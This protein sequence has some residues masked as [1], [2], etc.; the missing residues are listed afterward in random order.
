MSARVAAIGAIFVGTSVAWFVLGTTIQT[1]TWS[2]SPAL[3]ER[4]V[5]NW[6]GPHA[7]HRPTATLERPATTKE[8]FASHVTITP[9]KTVA[10]AD[11]RLQ[12]RQKGLLWYSTYAVAF[13]GRWTF[14]NP[15]D[16]PQNLTIVF[17]FPAPKAIY[18]DLVFTIDGKRPDL[19]VDTT[20]ATAKVLVG[21]REAVV[22]ETRYLS[23]G[24]ESW[25]YRF[26]KEVAEVK[27]FSLTVSTDFA[28]LDFPE[29][30]LSPTQKRRADKGWDLTWSYRNLMSG[31][32]ILIAMPEKLQPGPLAGEISYF[33]PVSLLFFFFVMFMITTLRRINLHP[34]HYF[35]LAT[36]FFAFHLLL[37]YLVDHVSI[38]TAFAAASV[39]SIFLTVSYLR[40]VTGFQFAMREA[41]LAQFVYLVLFSYAFFFE[42]FTGLAVTIGAIV[43][44]F[45]TMQMTGRIDWDKAR[46]HTPAEQAG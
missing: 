35:F 33:A 44:L 37:A 26:S 8:G 32:Q 42:G 2:R 25:A 9:E 28:N 11:L 16:S 1:R 4:V 3:R 39:V 10:E 13:S 36:S 29:G 6:G 14:R 45:V 20:G 7:Q 38:H 23:Q 24:L 46:F 34:V 18:D 21:A 40:L 30:A 17:P 43:T 27:D 5:S 15:D 41:A 12:H 22:L 31:Q 19:N